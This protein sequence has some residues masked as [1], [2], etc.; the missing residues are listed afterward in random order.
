MAELRPLPLVVVAVRSAV[1]VIVCCHRAGHRASW[2]GTGGC[3]GGGH[4]HRSDCGRCLCTHWPQSKGFSVGVWIGNPTAQ[5]RAQALRPWHLHLQASGDCPKEITSL[6]ARKISL[7]LLGISSILASVTR[8]CHIW[9]QN[10]SEE[11]GS[12]DYGSSLAQVREDFIRTTVHKLSPGKA[13]RLAVI[14]AAHSTSGLCP[15]PSPGVTGSKRSKVQNPVV[16]GSGSRDPNVTALKQAWTIQ[17]SGL[18]TA[19]ESY[20]PLS[21]PT[22]KSSASSVRLERGGPAE[23]RRSPHCLGSGVLEV[24]L[25]PQALNLYTLKVFGALHPQTRNLEIETLTS[26]TS[27]S[28][29]PTN[30]CMMSETPETPPA[31]FPPGHGAAG[32]RDAWATKRQPGACTRSLDCSASGRLS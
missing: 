31:P 19:Q 4:G 5:A 13:A 21:R 32:P 6:A 28:L 12:R 27:Y 20:I 16:Y 7:R 15:A 18:A 2:L 3:H 17:T 22:A 14:S 26:Y 23:Q 11:R 8:R 25:T 29:N 30:Q 1:V 24:P 10:A 9:V